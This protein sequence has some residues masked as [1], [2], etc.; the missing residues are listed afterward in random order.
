MYI[1]FN[2]IHESFAKADVIKNDVNIQWDPINY[3]T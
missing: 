3:I 1:Y 2:F